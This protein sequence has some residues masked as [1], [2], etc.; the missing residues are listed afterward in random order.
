[1][2]GLTAAADRTASRLPRNR[3]NTLS[4]RYAGSIVR[5]EPTFFGNSDP[6]GFR[7]S[8]S[9]RIRGRRQV[10]GGTRRLSG[11]KGD[12]GGKGDGSRFQ[13]SKG[14]SHQMWRTQRVQVNMASLPL[15]LR[16]ST[17]PNRAYEPQSLGRVRDPVR[18]AE[19]PTHD[20]GF[21]ILDFALRTKATRVS[22]PEALHGERGSSSIAFMCA[23][24]VCLCSSSSPMSSSAT[25]PLAIST[26]CAWISPTVIGR[27][28]PVAS[29]ER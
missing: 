18:I 10:I 6:T 19:G 2:P 28:R 9:Q 27:A 7:F 26:A 23:L 14:D 29:T 20:F 5:A 13:I 15:F 12:A 1:M 3:L 25:R 22:L 17:G 4:I 16:S 11:G 21:S 8:R 24:R